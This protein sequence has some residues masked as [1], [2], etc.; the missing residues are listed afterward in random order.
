MVRGR[1][2]VPRPGPPKT[3]PLQF[4]E[5]ASLIAWWDRREESERA[6]K[7]GG[8]RARLMKNIVWPFEV[9]FH[10][11]HSSNLKLQQILDLLPKGAAQIP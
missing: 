10:V 9:D 1:G 3:Q 2:S 5:F 7:V 8:W 4:E 6:W 11:G